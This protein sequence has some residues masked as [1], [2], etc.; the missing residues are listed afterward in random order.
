LIGREI[1][2]F[3]KQ[4]QKK[5]TLADLSLDDLQALVADL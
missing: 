4:P 2:M 5:I 1:G 3:G